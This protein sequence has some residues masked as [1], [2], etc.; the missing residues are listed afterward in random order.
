M[1]FT[2]AFWVPADKKRQKVLDYFMSADVWARLEIKLSKV[3]GTHIFSKNIKILS[4]A[5]S[6]KL[7]FLHLL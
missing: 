4:V 5:K 6:K 1:P 3:G 7:V 2:G